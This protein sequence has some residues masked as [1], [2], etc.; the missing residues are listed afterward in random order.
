MRPGANQ[1]AAIQGFRAP[2]GDSAIFR[3]HTHLLTSFVGGFNV[4]L[5]EVNDIMPSY[6]VLIYL[7]LSDLCME[8]TIELEIFY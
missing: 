1:G 4:S 6:F 3:F 7:D 8:R 5:L 2:T